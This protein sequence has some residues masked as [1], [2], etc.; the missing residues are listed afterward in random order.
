MLSEHFSLDEL[1]ASQTAVRRGIDNGPTPAVLGNLRTVAGQMERVRDLLGGRPVNVS[2]GYRSPAL[3]KAVGGAAGSAHV[4]GWAVDFTCRSF[5]SPLEVA[6]AIA[7]SD[8]QYDQLIHEY[9]RWVHISF[10]PALRQMDLTIGPK[11]TVAGL[12]AL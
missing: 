10:A 11:G 7:A 3:N 8:L 1:T 2:S 5:G 9:G 12:V 4:T 6:R